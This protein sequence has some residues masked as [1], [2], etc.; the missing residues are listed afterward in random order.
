MQYKNR[1]KIANHFIYKKEKEV[2]KTMY[3]EFRKLL[4]P[5]VKET[6]NQ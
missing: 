2:E 3:D 6:R 4:T 1:Y 5:Q